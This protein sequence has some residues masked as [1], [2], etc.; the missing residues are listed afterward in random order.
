M[1]Q[2]HEKV[3]A[4]LRTVGR[5]AMV[6]TLIGMMT[7]MQ[8]FAASAPAMTSQPAAAPETTSVT[9]NV[10]TQAI[11]IAPTANLPLAATNDMTY[12]NALPEAPSVAEES[13]SVKMPANMK[14]MM[15]DAAQQS[16]AL[17][18]KTTQKHTVNGGWL[19][20]GIVGSA[21]MAFG[22]MG[23]AISTKT[24]GDIAA[25]CFFVPGAAGAGFGFYNAFHQKQQ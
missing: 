7:S 22:I 23:Y 11:A 6:G 25:T 19:T 1:I 15:D 24:K 16:Q 20:L 9:D 21:V 2:L 17:T 3:G 4:Q 14:A 18:P 13:A 12:A 10:S 5:C 8:A